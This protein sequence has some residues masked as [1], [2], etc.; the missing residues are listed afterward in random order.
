M[1]LADLKAKST[2]HDL[3]LCHQALVRYEPTDK[4][5][6]INYARNGTNYAEFFLQVE[7]KSGQAWIVAY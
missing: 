3:R 4:S 2:G 1:R 6:W 5:W 7:D